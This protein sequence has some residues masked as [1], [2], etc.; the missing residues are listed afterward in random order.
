M[1]N[2]NRFNDKIKLYKENIIKFISNQNEQN[3][4]DPKNKINLEEIKDLDYLIGILFL[5][6]MNRYCKNNNILVH[7]YYIAYEL[8]N[9]FIKIKNK[10]VIKNNLNYSDIN[11]FYLGVSYNIDYLNSRVDNSNKTK[12]KINY[13]FSKYMIEINPYLT[14]LIDQNTCV[15]Q[16]L[17]YTNN[18]LNKK[19][20]KSNSNSS[21][22]KLS[23]SSSNNT[24]LHSDISVKSNGS[25]KSVKSV[26]SIRSVVS[27]NIEKTK[28]SDESFSIDKSND[29]NKENGSDSI[30]L[31]KTNLFCEDKCSDCWKNKVLQK[32]FIILLS[33]A[34][35]IGSGDIFEPNLIKLSE[36]YSNIFYT[37][38]KIQDMI[39]TNSSNITNKKDLMFE[40]FDNYIE[41]KNK[42]NYSLIELKITSDTI[43]QIINYIDQCI[44]KNLV[45]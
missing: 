40:L 38:L 7:G 39:L 27:V 4:L 1:N 31:N 5:T 32:F 23:N 6:E 26:K 28:D 11:N 37:Y 24:A 18:I 14:S 2:S 15:S 16:N 44:N 22:E 20:P 29:F 8:I 36:Y 21:L 33:T 42:L 35:F 13:N 34:K 19:N 12:L 3:N 45:I 25:D 17:N 30:I 41:Y 10:L 9:L 43:D